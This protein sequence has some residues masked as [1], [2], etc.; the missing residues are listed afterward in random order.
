[1]DTRFKGQYK[2][3][4]NAKQILIMLQEHGT[5]PASSCECSIYFSS[6]VIPYSYD[7]IEEADKY[8]KI[9]KQAAEA[10][11]KRIED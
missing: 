1:M 10:L 3:M 5:I 2:V 8:Y 6:D 11:K 7:T 9:T 4:N